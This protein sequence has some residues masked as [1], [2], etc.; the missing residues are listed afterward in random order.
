[1]ESLN[2][3]SSKQQLGN[4]RISIMLEHFCGA[5][6]YRVN[7]LNVSRRPTPRALVVASTTEI[8]LMVHLASKSLNLAAPVAEGE[9]C[10][11]GDSRQAQ[12]LSKGTI[13]YGRVVAPVRMGLH[14]MSKRD[15]TA[16]H[17]VGKEKSSL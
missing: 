12:N 7:S 13:G 14:D 16:P 2:Y 9:P 10:S 17:A 8:F 5:M 11:S 3:G 15:V 4:R 1:M 6:V